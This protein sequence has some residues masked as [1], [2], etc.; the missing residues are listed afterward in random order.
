MCFLPAEHEKSGCEPVQPVDGPEVLQVVLLGKD[1]H[2]SVVTVP[3][4]WV[5]LKNTGHLDVGLALKDLH[6]MMGSLNA[7]AHVKSS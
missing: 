3:T 6:S 4:A 7:R 1:E 5:N 2:Y